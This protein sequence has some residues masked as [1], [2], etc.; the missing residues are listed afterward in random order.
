MKS[1]YSKIVKNNQVT[2]GIPF[3]INIPLSLRNNQ[4]PETEAEAEAMENAEESVPKPEELLEKARQE[5]ELIIKEAELEADRLLGEARM[6]AEENA[7]KVQEEAWQ[8]GYAEGMEAAR[9]QNESVLAEAEEIRK[10]AAEEHDGIMAG[11]EAEAVELVLD[12]ARKAV[13]GELATNRGVILQLV[14]E[15]LSNCSDKNGAVLRASPADCDYIEENRDQLLAEVEG[16][17]SLEVKRDSTLKPGG[18]IVETSF[19]SIDAG[20]D[21]RL[22]KIE[23]AFLEQLGSR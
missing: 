18:C 22:G 15:A 11:L 9:Q 20:V 3:Q 19:G 16:A 14:K 2:Y 12:I 23:E 4:E 13:A 8:K 1:L 10:S 5:G 21:T 17:D 6:E 7:Q